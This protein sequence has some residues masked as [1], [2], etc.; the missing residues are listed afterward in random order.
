M[1]QAATCTSGDY[2]FAPIL[3]REMEEDPRVR[4]SQP[5]GGLVAR[6][7]WRQSCDS[8]PNPHCDLLG[9]QAPSIL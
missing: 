8:E 7:A 9:I 6:I 5:S 1:L 3:A 2:P 4:E